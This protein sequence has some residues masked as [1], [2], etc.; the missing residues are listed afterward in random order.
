MKEGRTDGRNAGM[1]ERRSA[2]S[3]TLLSCISLVNFRSIN[4]AVSAMACAERKRGFGDDDAVLASKGGAQGSMDG[5]MPTGGTST[6]QST[7]RVPPAQ[8]GSSAKRRRERQLRSFG[9]HEALSVRIARAE[10]SH[11]SAQK[12]G[13]PAPALYVHVEQLLLQVAALQR[14]V[15][16]LRGA[17]AA[18]AMHK[19]PTVA[20]PEQTATVDSPK[21]DR[22]STA[23]HRATTG[24][25]A[26]ADTA[27]GAN[28]RGC[29][30]CG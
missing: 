20:P 5:R 9:R 26:H 25:G 28:Y 7:D 11:H 14:E 16:S 17:L 10:C 22:A 3:S 19:E 27:E 18:M 29:I 30:C 4:L 2:R 24:S 6:G 13:A 15:D 12:C 23:M 1:N 8:G 21:E